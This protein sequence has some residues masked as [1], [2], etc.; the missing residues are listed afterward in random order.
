MHSDYERQHIS[1]ILL[2]PLLFRF[3]A[4][5]KENEEERWK[6]IEIGV[7]TDH[8]AYFFLLVLWARLVR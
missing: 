3:R 2:L 6:I 8:R 4:K 5:A 1:A 7:T